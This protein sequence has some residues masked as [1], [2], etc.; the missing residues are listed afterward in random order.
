MNP[1]SESEVAAA[2]AKAGKGR[3]LG[4]KIAGFSAL[5]AIAG[6]VGSGIRESF[7]LGNFFSEGAREANQTLKSGEEI[8][9]FGAT[10]KLNGWT[11]HFNAEGSTKFLEENPGR[12]V[13]FRLLRES[14]GKEILVTSYLNDFE[15]IPEMLRGPAKDISNAAKSLG[16][17]GLTDPESGHAGVLKQDFLLRPDHSG[18]PVLIVEEEIKDSANPNDSSTR[19]TMITLDIA[20]HIYT[21]DDRLEI[22]S[23]KPLSQN[24]LENLE[25]FIAKLRNYTDSKNEKVL[26][27]I[28]RVEVYERDFA[29]FEDDIL[30]TLNIPSGL[31]RDRV[32]LLDLIPEIVHQHQISEIDIRIDQKESADA[33]LKLHKFVHGKSVGMEWGGDWWGLIKKP[34]PLG[35]CLLLSE[36]AATP[37]KDDSGIYIDTPEFFVAGVEAIARLYPVEFTKRYLALSE[38]DRRQVKDFVNEVVA[39]LYGNRWGRPLTAPKLIADIGKL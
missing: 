22:R 39:P 23:E 3:G 14:G 31:V 4:L 7:N 34:T 35:R 27:A 32:A 2:E 17:Q 26:S 10:A 36:Y 6:Y 9:L 37:D 12:D 33:L 21:L 29:K 20:T 38:V 25:L 24:E 13:R 1:P 28:E 11:L 15:E 5:A 8:K 18:A 19:R 30:G 16:Y